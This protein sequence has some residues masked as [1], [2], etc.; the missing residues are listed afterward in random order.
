MAEEKE[1]PLTREDVL[2]LIRENG[3]KAEG[4]DL[5]DRKFADAIDLSNLDLSGIKLNNAHLFRANFNGSNLDRAI[6]L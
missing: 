6:M 2:K 4:L 5:S 1:R 3:G